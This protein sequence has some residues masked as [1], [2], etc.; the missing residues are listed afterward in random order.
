MKTLTLIDTLNDERLEPFLPLLSEVWA[1]G[2]LTDLEIA[3]V[4]MALTRRPGIDLSCKEALQH[5]LDPD[6][7]PTA[8]DLNALRSLIRRSGDPV[9]RPLPNP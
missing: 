6:N 2:E 3:A 5:W 4:C 7:P 8:H 1:D 9:F